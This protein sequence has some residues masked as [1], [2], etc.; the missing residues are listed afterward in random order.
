MSKVSLLL[1]VEPRTVTGSIV[2]PEAHPALVVIAFIWMV[3]SFSATI[4]HVPLKG[5]KHLVVV[6]E[7]HRGAACDKWFILITCV[8]NFECFSM[9]RAAVS[10]TQDLELPL[11]TPHAK[12]PSITV[13]IV[14]I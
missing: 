8:L 2:L 6:S 1:A 13:A 11:S 12:G 7:N 9:D 3:V 4:L 5:D 10:C 14:H